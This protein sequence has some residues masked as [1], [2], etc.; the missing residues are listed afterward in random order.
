MNTISKTG[1]F[2]INVWTPYNL[3]SNAQR[4]RR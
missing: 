2:F 4:W 3:L 1:Y